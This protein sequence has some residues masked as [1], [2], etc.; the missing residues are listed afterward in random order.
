[1]FDEI[2][3]SRPM[4]VNPDKANLIK[5]TLL[6][7]RFFKKKYYNALFN[8]ALLVIF[9]GITGSTLYYK[10]KTKLSTT[11]KF[12]KKKKQLNNIYSKLQD[13]SRVNPNP[14]MITTLPL[15]NQTHPDRQYFENKIF[16]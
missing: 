5:Q 14:N 12:H 3:N 4:L 10:H 11:D 7:C 2:Q 8:L 6:K 16:M 1:M 13:Y 9:L 15:L